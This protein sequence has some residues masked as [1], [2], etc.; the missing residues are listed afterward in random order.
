MKIPKRFILLVNQLL[1]LYTFTLQQNKYYPKFI[2]FLGSVNLKTFD[3]GTELCSP[4][5][6]FLE[7]P[8][9]LNDVDIF[10]DSCFSLAFWIQKRN[11]QSKCTVFEVAC[12]GELNFIN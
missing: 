2:I 4:V 7:F 11:L 10:A 3:P 12:K 9:E 1:I 5:C 8:L 6:H